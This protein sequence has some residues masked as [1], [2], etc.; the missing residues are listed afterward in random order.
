MIIAKL[1]AT[2]IAA[3]HEIVF[4]IFIEIFILY[5]DLYPFICCLYARIG[6]LR[7]PSPIRDCIT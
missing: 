3:T 5:A 6:L 4:I 7:P 1:A 2:P